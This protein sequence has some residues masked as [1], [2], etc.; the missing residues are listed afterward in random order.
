[1]IFRSVLS[2]EIL[3]AGRDMVLKGE[4]LSG[5][6]SVYRDSVSILFIRKRNG[7]IFK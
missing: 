2:L 5:W 6:D 7:I 3:D 1:M 4:S